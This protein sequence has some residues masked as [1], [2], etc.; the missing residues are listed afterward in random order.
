M[1]SHINFVVVGVVRVHRKVVFI[2]GF[3]TDRGQSLLALFNLA[4]FDWVVALDAY[5][6]SSKQIVWR[7]IMPLGVLYTG[8][9]RS[10]WILLG[11][12]SLT[13]IEVRLN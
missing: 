4:L 1:D 5:L 11:P 9:K 3:L 2:R 8:S 6:M 10:N 7:N 12:K 13:V